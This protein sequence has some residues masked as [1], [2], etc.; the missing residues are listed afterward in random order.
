[1]VDALIIFVRNP[2][3]GAVK[4]RLA[5]AIGDDRA[6]R[7]Y[8]RM[9]EHTRSITRYVDCKKFLFYSDQVDTSDAW[10][11]DIY[12]KRLQVGD[13]LGKRMQQAFETVFAKFIGDP[14][15]KVVIIGSD[16]ME[17]T[18]TLID[19][20]FHVLDDHDLVIGP[21]NDGGYYLLGMKQEHRSLF[22]EKAWS[23]DTVLNDTFKD[24][25]RLRLSH[26]ELPVLSDIDEIDDLLRSPLRRMASTSVPLKLSI[27]IPTRN[28]ANNIEKTM[29]ML[30]AR[31]SRENIKE[32][33]V[34]D[35]ES[36]DGTALL[37]AKAGARV[38]KS[39]KGRGQQLQ[40]GGTLATGDV[41]YFL[42]VDCV[43][44]LGFDRMIIDATRAGYR[45]GCFKLRFDVVHPI[46]KLTAWFSRFGHQWFRAGDES[47]FVEKAVF[48]EAGG[49]DPTRAIME[50]VEIIPRL[51]KIAAFAVIQ[52]QITSAARRYINKGIFRLQALYVIL[53]IM[54][55]ERHGSNVLEH[56]YS[57]FVK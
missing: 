49:Y 28:E 40:I 42:H 31:S 48:M 16:C 44:P 46:L 57:R 7:V 8:Q 45:S 20:A 34:I 9:L 19:A 4:T 23:T 21:A 55:V 3:R 6:F 5:S 27:I 25:T 47:L 37:A 11:N 43:P 32:I 51:K 53:R 35:G 52:H 15:S 1:M 18:S 29:R 33:M 12:D 39:R 36:S 38:I 50:D 30:A 54:D 22:E 2:V 56:F 10:E 14:G 24:A 41:L 26:A 13:N 17:I